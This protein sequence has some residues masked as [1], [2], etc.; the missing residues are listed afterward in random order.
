MQTNTHP[1]I[2]LADIIDIR[3]TADRESGNDLNYEN[4]KNSIEQIG[5][6]Q[7]LVLNRV[8]NPIDLSLFTYELC[9][10]GRR[11]KASMELGATVAVH[12]LSCTPGTPGYVFV[13]E[14]SEH[15]KLE[16]ELDENIQRR[17][18]TWQQEA[19]SIVRVH[20]AR[21]KA[22]LVERLEDSSKPKWGL[23]QTGA[24][25]NVSLGD[26][27]NTM[28]IVAALRAN[29]KEITEAANFRDALGILLQ[30][31]VDSANKLLVAQ[32][33]SSVNTKV[34]PNVTTDTSKPKKRAPGEPLI[35]DFGDG[36]DD[37][38]AVQPVNRTLS[39]APGVETEKDVTTI[40]PLSSMLFHGPMEIVG[41]K[42][43]ADGSMDFGLADFPYG[44]DMENLDLKSQSRVDKEHDVE[45]NADLMPKLLKEYYR[46]LKD[47][48]FLCFFYDLDYHER[49]RAWGEEIGFKVQ[50]WPI[51]WAKS[52]PCRNQAAGYNF[53]KTT[54][55]CY[56]F[57][58]G[59]AT[60]NKTQTTNWYV[61]DG[62]VERKMY[63]NPFAKPFDMWKVL[64]DACAL[65]GMKGLDLC[66]GE[67]SSLR[68]MI[69]CGL[70]PHGAEISELHYNPL[71]ENIKNAYKTLTR[72]KVEFR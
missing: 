66:C 56:V 45:Q 31:K 40:I 16:I 61:F 51:V 65:P 12:G 53:T 7:P 20:E 24:L 28:T 38:S 26:M 6:I 52:H 25:M 62:A 17:N 21:Q 3:P 35:V 22:S 30:R 49:L 19:V 57:R 37:L 39:P 59:N 27:S 33:L 63:D 44:I 34:P 43:F 14:L 50:R 23:R 4:F 2:L 54:E 29:D 1:D 5:V 70:M 48:S 8:Q 10:G 72:G 36:D 58:K 60:L 18:I 71:V 9:A 11:R 32:G 42:Q 67:G 68:A 55:V 47:K 41:P 15:Q 64:I 46:I 13:D 69:M